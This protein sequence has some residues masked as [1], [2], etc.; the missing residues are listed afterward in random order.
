[1]DEFQQSFK[2][3]DYQFNIDY[4]SPVEDFIL[5]SAQLNNGKH[6]SAVYYPYEKLIEIYSDSA[7]KR[8]PYNDE[9]LIFSLAFY[10]KEDGFFST[11][12]IVN[13]GVFYKLHDVTEYTTHDGAYFL[14]VSPEGI[15]L[16]DNEN[17]TQT[18][19]DISTILPNTKITIDLSKKR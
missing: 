10:H 7:E 3:G 15:E 16:F 17:D 6:L 14:K 18:K 12:E 11:I 19:L 8:M 1:M 5:Y 13:K 2:F 4:E 9:D